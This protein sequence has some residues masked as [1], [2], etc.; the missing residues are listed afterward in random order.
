MLQLIHNKAY[1][2]ILFLPNGT[3]IDVDDNHLSDRFIQ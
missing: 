1:F 3:V 2:E